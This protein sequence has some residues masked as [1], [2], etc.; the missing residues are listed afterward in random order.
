MEL[1]ENRHKLKKQKTKKQIHSVRQKRTC[2]KTY[3]PR[4]KA[5]LRNKRHLGE[6]SKKKKK[7]I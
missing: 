6:A 7:N 3:V 4:T 2:K 1:E 5:K